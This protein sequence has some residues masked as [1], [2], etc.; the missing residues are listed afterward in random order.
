MKDNKTLLVTGASSDVGMELIKRI[1]NN[2]SLI[3][4]QYRNMNI[5]LEEIG[6][7][8]GE[9][10]ML[11]RADISNE[12]DVQKMNNQII[13]SGIIVDHIVHLAAMKAENLQFRKAEWENVMKHIDIDVKSIYVVL[14]SF[15]PQMTKQKYGKIVFMLSSYTVGLPPKFQTSYSIA[16]HALLGLMQSLAAEYAEQGITFNGVSPN[17]I[18]T[19]FLSDLPHWLMEQNAQ[20]SML[21]RNLQVEDVVPLFIYLLSDGSDAITG[22]NFEIMNKL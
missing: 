16:K 4:A 12:N 6:Q 8:Y 5:E 7:R 14:K 13:E 20:N 21:K 19:K 18:E 11:I 15:L 17:M 2:Y 1:I 3:I 10:I 22:Q 9:K